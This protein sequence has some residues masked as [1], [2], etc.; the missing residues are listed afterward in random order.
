M[1]SA[2]EIPRNCSG[3]QSINPEKNGR[4]LYNNNTSVHFAG[5]EYH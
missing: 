3:L 1:K 5:Y 4:N 2:H